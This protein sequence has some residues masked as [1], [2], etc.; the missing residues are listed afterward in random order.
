MRQRD[1]ESAFLL[2]VEE[3]RVEKRLR[4]GWEEEGRRYFYLEFEVGRW[5]GVG[6]GLPRLSGSRSAKNRPT[7]LGRWGTCGAAVQN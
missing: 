4:I 5:V 7:D 6:A 2:G 1:T 3:S